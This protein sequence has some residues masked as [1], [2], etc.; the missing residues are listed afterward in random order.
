MMKL[1]TTMMFSLL[2]IVGCSDSNFTGG[3]NARRLT[4]GKT[5][6]PGQDATAGDP[7]ANGDGTNG[8]NNG[9]GSNGNNNGGPTNHGGLRADEG[10]AS[11][12]RVPMMMYFDTSEGE[13]NYKGQ[14]IYKVKRAGGLADV[15]LHQFQSGATG[16]K[17]IE[18]VCTCGY[19]NNMDLLI[20][21]DN[22][23]QN[24]SGW[25]NEVITSSTKPSGNIDDWSGFLSKYKN[26]PNH[27]IYL[28][29]FDQVSFGGTSNESTC[30]VFAC[31]AG[32]RKW[33]YR[34]DTRMAFVCLVD[35]C[36]NKAAGFSLKFKDMKGP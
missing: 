25:T 24:L 20:T 6:Q 3:S 32:D 11:A 34:D 23:E 14:F 8:G 36:A 9:D 2:L 18:D 29:G 5:G 22:K 33:G 28:G 4:D 7:N 30:G 12:P 16:E 31:G 26:L 35:Q 1:L 19:E 15:V 13:S 17:K 27:A 21:A 10:Y